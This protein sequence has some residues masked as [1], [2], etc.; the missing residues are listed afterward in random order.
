VPASNCL[1]LDNHLCQDL[2]QTALFSVFSFAGYKLAFNYL[3]A[4]RFVDAV[5][6]SHK[7]LAIHPDY[8]RI[9]KEILD[10]A[11]SSIRV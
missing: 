4:K 5:D 3:K 10:K 2:L 11:R 9:R 8:P 1:V 6:V 7:V